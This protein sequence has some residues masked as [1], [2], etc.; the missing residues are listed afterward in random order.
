MQVL[1]EQDDRFG[2][3]VFVLVSEIHSQLVGLRRDGQRTD[4]TDAIASIPCCVDRCL[5]DR[6]PSSTNDWLK[7]EARFVNEYDAS[8]LLKALFLV[9]AIRRDANALRRPRSVHAPVFPDVVG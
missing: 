5:S 7:H 6:S 4:H 1:D 3:D 8:L 2:F 9:A